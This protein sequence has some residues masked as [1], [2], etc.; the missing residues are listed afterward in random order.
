[1]GQGL[2]IL[3]EMLNKYWEGINQGYSICLACTSLSYI[4]SSGGM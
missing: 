1:M 3:R 2:E 4:P